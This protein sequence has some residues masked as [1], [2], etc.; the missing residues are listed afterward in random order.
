MATASTT[1]PHQTK[2]RDASTTWGAFYLTL[3][4]NDDFDEYVFS[5]LESGDL[6]IAQAENLWH[7]TDGYKLILESTVIGQ[8]A[9][10]SI[11]CLKKTW[12][13]TTNSDYDSGSICFE[14]KYGAVNTLSFYGNI[15]TGVTVITKA[16]NKWYSETVGYTD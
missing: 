6:N 10:E 9:L 1:A 13:V 7:Y 3:Q 15:D 8:T 12:S 16:Q 4:G 14:T 5:L 11:F 2:I